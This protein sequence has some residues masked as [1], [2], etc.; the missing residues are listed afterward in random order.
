MAF[1][2][3]I[4]EGD[5]LFQLPEKDSLEYQETLRR[6]RKQIQKINEQ[7]PEKD[8]DMSYPPPPSVNPPKRAYDRAIRL[9]RA[10]RLY[11]PIIP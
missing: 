8:V 2:N 10:P 5:L 4:D 11:P 3:N 9:A 1:N 6:H 7:F